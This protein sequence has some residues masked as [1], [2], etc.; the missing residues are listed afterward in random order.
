MAVEC[1][2]APVEL[3]WAE[4]SHQF[5][6][7]RLKLHRHWP[8][9]LKRVRC[10]KGISKCIPCVPIRA[11]GLGPVY[12]TAGCD[13]LRIMRLPFYFSTP[14]PDTNKLSQSHFTWQQAKQPPSSFSLPPTPPLLF[15]LS[16]FHPLLMCD[17]LILN[18]LFP[19]FWSVGFTCRW[20]DN[21]HRLKGLPSF[22]ML[23]D[24]GVSIHPL[25]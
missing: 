4:F 24:N 18:I 25:C 8:F 1:K 9:T 23:S 22:L 20:V 17:T 11:G 13:K 3:N 15:F 6:T 7:C 12:R 14:Q 10:V 21:L 19:V 5:S 2:W 16:Y